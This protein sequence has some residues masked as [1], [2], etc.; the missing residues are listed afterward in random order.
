MV[1]PRLDWLCITHVLNVRAESCRLRESIRPL[2]FR[3]NTLT[4]RLRKT[5]K[6]DKWLNSNPAYYTDSKPLKTSRTRQV[7]HFSPRID[8]G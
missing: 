6:T 4:P 1:T 2:Y 8:S 3:P 5:A 7:A